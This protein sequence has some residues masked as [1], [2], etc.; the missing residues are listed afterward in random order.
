MLEY[1]CRRSI[2][3]VLR[4]LRHMEPVNPYAAPQSG[5]PLEDGHAPTVPV[6]LADILRVATSVTLANF[7]SI[8]GIMLTFCLPI[9]LVE[10]YLSYFPLELEETGNPFYRTVIL[11]NVVGLIPETGV[12]AIAAAALEGRPGTYRLGFA[13]G[14]AAWPR[15]FVTRLT[16]TISILLALVV[17]VLPG[18]FVAVR[19]ALAEPV[20]LIENRGGMSAPGRSFELTRGRSWSMFALLCIAYG[21][22]YTLG[23]LTRIPLYFFDHWLLYATLSVGIDLFAAWVAVVLVAA[24]WSCVH[25]TIAPSA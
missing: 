16:V 25:Q 14:F 13:A 2:A 22:L 17:F 15:V 7:L 18:I 6:G 23:Y 11:K 21:A 1:T 19:T 9:E 20:A 8:V 24:Y 3:Y 4:H 12:M 5:S 10:A